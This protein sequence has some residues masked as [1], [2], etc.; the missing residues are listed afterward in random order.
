[1]KQFRITDAQIIGL[2]KQADAGMSVKELSRS[3]GFSQPVILPFCK[4]ARSRNVTQP[5]PASVSV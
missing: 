3:G 2:L 5:W 1:M 4:G